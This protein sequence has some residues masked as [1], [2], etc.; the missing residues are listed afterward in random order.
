M[1]RKGQFKKGGGRVGDGTSS[2]GGSG[3]RKS[4]TR[5]A[6]SGSTALVR[7][8][9]RAMRPVVRNDIVVIDDGHH[10]GHYSRPTHRVAGYVHG[11]GGGGGR[12]RGKR[13]GGGGS[14]GVT[15]MKI[16]AAA[17]VLGATFGTQAMAPQAVR[18]A[19]AKIPGAKT[20]G[21]ATTVG[22]G[23]GAVYKYTRIGGRFR[24][25]L[26]A[27]GVVGVVSAAMKIGDQGT[28]FKFLG[29]GDDDVVSRR[30]Y[31]RRDGIMDV[32]T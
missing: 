3:K 25:W 9:T 11:G 26:A 31:G 8:Q 5:V 4:R 10:L 6:S 7:S 1:A 15:L 17:A 12:R 21:A 29:D 2:R 13:G 19:A 30:R 20:F 16:A 14:S 22:L 28:S 23:L 24:P 32:E 27:A 18:D